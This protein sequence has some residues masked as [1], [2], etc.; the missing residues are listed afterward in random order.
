[1]DRLHVTDDIGPTVAQQLR[2]APRLA[3]AS[4]RP[5]SIPAATPPALASSNP[6]AP[7]TSSP[8][9]PRVQYKRYYDALRAGNHSYAIAGFRNFV[10]RF[11]DHDHADNARYWLGEAFYDQ[12][13]YRIALAEFRK[14]VTDHAGGNK[15]PDA[16]LKIGYCHIALGEMTD[17]RAALQ[18]VIDRFP[19]SQPARLAAERLASLDKD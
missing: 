17:A 2:E 7:P 16:M 8:G 5:D 19:R 18:R 3:R 14:V 1:M 4:A 9:D 12:R 10:E 13:E 15:V 11:P 6:P